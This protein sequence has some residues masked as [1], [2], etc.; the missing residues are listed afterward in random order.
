MELV[1]TDPRAPQT[2]MC[3]KGLHP[4]IPENIGVRGRSMSRGFQRFCRPCS[5]AWYADYQERRKE[6]T[7][8][9]TP[10]PP[11]KASELSYLRLMVRC[12]HCGA[13]PTES[14]SGR[15]ITPHT[16]G[17]FGIAGKPAPPRSKEVAPKTGRPGSRNV[18]TCRSGNHSWTEENIGTASNGKRFCKPCKTEANNRRPR[19]GRKAGQKSRL[20]QE[21]ELQ[22]TSPKHKPHTHCRSGEHPW[23][24]GNVRIKFRDDGSVTRSCVPCDRARWRAYDDTRRAAS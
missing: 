23:V 6:L 11:L 20:A 22:T 13:V 2:G 16:P 9:Y 15:V 1:S 7:E 18:D 8:A 17:C 14:E 19:T 21:H 3:R 5:E 4:W 24:V 10:P 12:L